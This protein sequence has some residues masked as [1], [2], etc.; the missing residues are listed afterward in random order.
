MNKPEQYNHVSQPANDGH[1]NEVSEEDFN[2]LAEKGKKLLWTWLIGAVV[3]VVCVLYGDT[4]Q[5]VLAVLVAI[6]VYI[7]TRNYLK[8][9]AS[10]N[11]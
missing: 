7:S 10:I 4:A 1:D 5:L 6:Y 9:A 3:V 11:S 2:R 8:L